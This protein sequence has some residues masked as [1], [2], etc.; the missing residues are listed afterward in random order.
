MSA[1]KESKEVKTVEKPFTVISEPYY[2]EDGNLQIKKTI[3]E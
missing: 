1:K 3:V 2:D